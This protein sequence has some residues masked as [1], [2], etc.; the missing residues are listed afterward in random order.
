MRARVYSIADN[1]D[2][3]T[4]TNVIQMSSQ[5][6]RTEGHRFRHGFITD[7]AQPSPHRPHEGP[8]SR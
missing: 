5:Q 6:A 7:N 3:I 8:S 1:L 4:F 2:A